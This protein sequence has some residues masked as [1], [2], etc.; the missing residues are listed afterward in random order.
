[1]MMLAMRAFLSAAPVVF[2]VVTTSL[3]ASKNEAAAKPAD[4]AAP[5]AGGAAPATDGNGAAD[6]PAA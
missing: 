1:M 6:K 3:C 5:A 4:A 2:V